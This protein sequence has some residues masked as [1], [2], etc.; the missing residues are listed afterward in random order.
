MMEATEFEAQ[1]RRQMTA[2]EE[3]FAKLKQQCYCT[4]ADLDFPRLDFTSLDFHW[5]LK[6]KLRATVRRNGA[7]LSLP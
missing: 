5:L 7:A 3:A 1:S 6:L 4:G 2:L